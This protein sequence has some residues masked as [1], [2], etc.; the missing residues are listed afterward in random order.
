MVQNSSTNPI[1]ACTLTTEELATRKLDIRQTLL[2]QVQE[3]NP[4]SNGHQLI[5]INT[6]NTKQDIATFIA[7]EQQCCSFLS[8]E[9]VELP[10]NNQLSL[11]ITGPNGTKEFIAKVML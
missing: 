6:N 7:A 9:L 8:F 1:L 10:D 2:S 3:S 11:D 5:F 4:L